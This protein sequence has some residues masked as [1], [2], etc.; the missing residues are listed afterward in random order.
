MRMFQFFPFDSKDISFQAEVMLGID[1]ILL[2]FSEE[3]VFYF[4]TSSEIDDNTMGD[5]DEQ[6]ITETIDIF[7]EVFV[8][9]DI[10]INSMQYSSEFDARFHHYFEGIYTY[11]ANSTQAILGKQR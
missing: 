10:R 9:F 8:G 7:E 2:K 3:E 6:Y 5:F 4:D 11:M 1:V